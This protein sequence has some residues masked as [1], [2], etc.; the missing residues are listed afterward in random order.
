MLQIIKNLIISNSFIFYITLNLYGF[1]YGKIYGHIEKEKVILKNKN[2]K[3]ILPLKSKIYAFDVIKDWKEYTSHIKPD[4]T[5]N[6]IEIFDFSEPKQHHL[7]NDMVYNC[8]YLPEDMRSVKI[9][10]DYLKPEESDVI[11]D[12]G[13]NCGLSALYLSQK[14]DNK[15]VVIAV[16]PD[17]LNYEVLC[18]NIA[19]WQL[20]NIIPL[21]CAVWK[22]KQE[23]V[24]SQDSSLGSCV[25]KFRGI[26]TDIVKVQ[27]YSLYDICEQYNLEKITSVKMDIEGSEYVLF[28]N[29]DKFIN[30]YRPRFVIEIHKNDS[31]KIDIEYFTNKFKSLNYKCE[32]MTKKQCEDFPL[33]FAIPNDD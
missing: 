29:I 7:K 27:A 16:E 25:D 31:S 4:A 23:L 22:E 14:A 11:L 28:E 32:V 33:V 18:K 30:Q 12:L 1:L 2:Q 5:E 20:N 3:F 26:K 24:F 15:C 19:Q 6:G 13:A 10:V 8:S 9:Y 17:K 21:N